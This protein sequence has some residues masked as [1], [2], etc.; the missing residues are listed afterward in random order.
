MLLGGKFLI[1]HEF[2][3]CL[4]TVRLKFEFDFF[5]FSPFL[6]GGS[7]LIFQDLAKMNHHL[8]ESIVKLQGKIINFYGL[9]LG[10]EFFG[11]WSLCIIP[12]LVDQTYLVKD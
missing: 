10:N 11:Q 5:D 3:C 7:N 1:L 9:I 8:G 6:G 2:D 12:L 4:T